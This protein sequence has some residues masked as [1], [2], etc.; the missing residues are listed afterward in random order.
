MAT[1]RFSSVTSSPSVSVSSVSS[2]FWETYSLPS[3]AFTP[4]GSLS[5]SATFFAVTFPGSVCPWT[6]SMR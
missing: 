4:M 5:P 3:T 6:W 1:V 2:C